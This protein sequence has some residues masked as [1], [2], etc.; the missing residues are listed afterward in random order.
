MFTSAVIFI[1]NSVIRKIVGNF[2]ICH[3]EVVDHAFEC[4]KLAESV[5]S[6]VFADPDTDRPADST[7][8]YSPVLIPVLRAQTIE[9]V[10]V[11]SFPGVANLV[12]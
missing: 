12:L 9:R 6:S 1:K 3:F 10:E 7:L 4:N 2:I 8:I 5:Q 11:T